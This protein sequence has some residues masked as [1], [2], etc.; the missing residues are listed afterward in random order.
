MTNTLRRCLLLLVLSVGQAQAAC[1]G[2]GLL[3][4]ACMRLADTWTR[5]ENDFYLPFHAHHFRFA[6]SKEKIDSFRENN[7]GLGYGRSLYN[8][9]GNWN[10]VYG[11][12][13]LDS[14]SKPQFFL[15]YSHQWV[16]GEPKGLHS[17]IGYTA[18]LTA[19]ANLLHYT[20]VPLI[21]PLASV[22]YDNISLNSTY[23]PGG[24]NNG[25]I[26][27]FWSRLGF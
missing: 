21:L 8:D 4:Q 13:F 3:D 19:R 26:L 11:M 1:D 18:F 27:F 7:W 6:Y 10:G 12:S 14:N 25:N 17:G 24:K 22:N 5:G 23:V 15:G 20:P 16:W 2:N 9:S